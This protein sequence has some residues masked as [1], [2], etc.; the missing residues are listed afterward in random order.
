MRALKCPP[1][2]LPYN[3]ARPLR[4]I[5]RWTEPHAQVRRRR[6]LRWAW[7]KPGKTPSFSTFL[8][9]NRDVLEPIESTPEQIWKGI[10]WNRDGIFFQFLLLLVLSAK[11]S[12]L[13]WEPEWLG[14]VPTSIASAWFCHM[15]RN[16]NYARA[17]ELVDASEDQVME[18]CSSWSLASGCVCD[19]SHLICFIHTT[20]VRVLSSYPCLTLFSIVYFWLHR[21]Y[22]FLTV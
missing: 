1:Q 5:E 6:Y 13:R 17:K 14:D 3:L 22:Q 15:Q 11:R 4:W 7:S 20:H 19:S 16:E 21:S 9:F 8:Y 2:S 10:R 12:I 18:T